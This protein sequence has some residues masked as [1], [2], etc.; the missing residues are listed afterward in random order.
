MVYLTETGRTYLAAAVRVYLESVPNIHANKDAYNGLK[1]SYLINFIS[2]TFCSSARSP[3]G[4]HYIIKLDGDDIYN[5]TDA[6]KLVIE[7]FV[8]TAQ[9][10]ASIHETLQRRR[11]I[12]VVHLSFFWTDAQ[13]IYR[14]HGCL[15]VFDAR[16][17]K[18]HFFNPWGYVDHWLTTKF[19]EVTLV[20]GF[21]PARPQE[22]AWPTEDDSMQTTLDENQ[23]NISGSCSLYCVLVAVLCT[24][25]G[26]GKPRV[27]AN[28]ITE[29]MKQ[30]DEDNGYNVEAQN[31]AHTHMTRLWHWMNH[32]SDLAHRMQSTPILQPGSVNTQTMVQRRTARRVQA[33]DTL[34][35]YPPLDGDPNTTVQRIQRRRRLRDR[36]QQ[37]LLRHPVLHLGHA[38][39][40]NEI[41]EDRTMR[42]EAHASILE[43]MFPSS[44][45]CNVLVRTGELCTRRACGGQ[46]LCWQHRYYTRNHVLMGAGR[47]RC[48]AEQQPCI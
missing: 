15:L 27:M 32:L 31:P 40:D 24:R 11:G 42:E 41:A 8:L 16:S 47:M 4:H 12:S 2:Q 39:T 20:D 46:P 36:Q 5:G 3:Q 14:G 30:I 29:A 35:A 9:H 37:Y 25:F 18:Q 45:H 1:S 10:E 34:E 26:F 19:A 21:Q 6:D 38:V 7:N 43:F 17:K 13:N 33:M 22:D 44:L 23:H 28:L 48:A